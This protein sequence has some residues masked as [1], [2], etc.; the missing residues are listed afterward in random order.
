MDQRGPVDESPKYMKPKWGKKIGAII[1][2][3]DT[4]YYDKIPNPHPSTLAQGRNY[5]ISHSGTSNREKGEILKMSHTLHVIFDQDGHRLQQSQRDTAAQG[6]RLGEID[7]IL[8]T[9]TQCDALGKFYR[10]VVGGILWVVVGFQSHLSVADI[11]LA[12]KFDASF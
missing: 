9:E 2:H 10:D 11:A 1:I 12:G 8:E 6:S 3:I 4:I 7:E 5:H